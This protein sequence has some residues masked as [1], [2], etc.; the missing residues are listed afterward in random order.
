MWDLSEAIDNFDLVDA[1]DAWGQAAVDAEYLV[2]DDDGER[3]EVEHV[4][5]VVPDVGVAV[6]ARALGVEA[7]GLGYAA[8][9]VV[10]ANEVHSSWVAEL[11]AHEEGDGFNAEHAAVDIVAWGG[12]A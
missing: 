7:I 1:V 4:R 3:Q 2:V 5:E 6:F 8:G 12:L 10:A 9:F 11:K